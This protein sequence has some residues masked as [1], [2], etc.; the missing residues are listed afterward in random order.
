MRVQFTLQQRVLLWL[1][2][3]AIFFEAFDIAIVN[4]ALP[5]LAKDLHVSLASAQWVQTIYLLSYSGC[6]LLGGRLCDHFGSK[7]IFLAG[8]F[9]FGLAS[10]LAALSHQL[11]EL[12]PA[13]AGQGIG[14]SLAMPAAIS[15]LSRYFKEEEQNRIAFGIFG[16]FAAIGFAGGLSL[17]GLVASAFNWRWMFGINPPVI[18]L[19]LITGSLF[20]PNEE[21]RKHSSLPVGTACWLTITLLLFSYS[22]H[23]V[24][25]L[26]WKTLPLLAA[27]VI[28]GVLL[29]KHDQRQQQPF[30]EHGI[31]RSP[32]AIRGL[33]AFTLLGFSFLPFIAIITLALYAVMGW[34]VQATGLLLFPYSIGSA[35]VSRLLL[36]VLFKKAGVSGT[37]LI[38]MCCLLLAASSLALGIYTHR[39]PFYLVAL[40]L[41]NSLS[42]SIAF[43]ALTILSLTGVPPDKQG[44]AAGLQSCI[45]VIGSGIGL[46]AVGLCLRYGATGESLLCACVIVLSGSVLAVQQLMKA[47]RRT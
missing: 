8:M 5:L 32:I 13:R 4:L 41:A 42:I 31:Y 21:S 10:L 2:C 16:A 47:T 27:A 45:N 40:L 9:L 43:P 34:G 7:R 24:G 26:G 12:I 14:A 1:A 17:G 18:A 38:S 35:L 11:Y 22:I 28:S 19:V 44:I 6:L 39:L 23:E 36:P 3:S 33:T 29:L 46:S 20:I 30:F 15:M 37:G 25:D